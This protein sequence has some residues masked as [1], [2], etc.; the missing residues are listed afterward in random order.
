MV[1]IPSSF[2]HLRACPC[3][4]TTFGRARNA[5]FC[6]KQCV[7]RHRRSTLAEFP[8][9]KPHATCPTC[10]RGFAKLR[11]DMTYCSPRCR[12]LAHGNRRRRKM[13]APKDGVTRCCEVCGFEFVSRRWNQV[14]CSKACKHHVIG[15]RYRVR[16]IGHA[17]DREL[18][19]SPALIRRRCKAIQQQRA[20]DGASKNSEGRLSPPTNLSAESDP[21]SDRLRSGSTAL[22][23]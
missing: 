13:N 7:Y 15:K 21:N 11:R 22:D 17:S 9:P 3:G 6:C 20:H 16:K 5:R 10:K 4:S 19:P 12:E 8:I 18:F 23:G 14:F 2:C 1:A